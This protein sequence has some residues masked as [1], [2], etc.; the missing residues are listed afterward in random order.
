[1]RAPDPTDIIWTNLGYPEKIKNK[2][3]FISYLFLIML[4]IFGF[5]L[6]FGIVR[7]K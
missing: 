1:M 2:R 4:L 5:G 3:K 7:L 6:I